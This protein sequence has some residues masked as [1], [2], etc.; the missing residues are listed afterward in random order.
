MRLRQSYTPTSNRRSVRLPVRLLVVLGGVL[1][2]L[3]MAEVGVRM[4]GFRYLNLY[5]ED[6]DVGFAHRP[7]AEGWWQREGQTYI[8]IS[9]AGLR[10]REHAQVKPPGTVRV[11]VLGDSFAEA[12]QVPMEAAFWAVAEQR[13]QGCAAMGGRRVEMLNFGVSGSSTA[14]ELITL[15]RRVWQYAPDVV[16]LLVTT[17]ND[18]RDNSRLLNR[19]YAGLPLPYFV[20]QNG[21][22]VLDD[23]LL[24]RRNES[25]SFRWHQSALGSSLNRLRDHVRLLS[26]L[27]RTRAALQTYQQKRKDTPADIGYEP[28][29]D[30]KV[31]LAP[32]DPAW[33]EAWRV[34]EGL[35]LLMR[36]EVQAHGAK[37]LLVTGSSGI[38]VYPD[39]AVRQHFMQS[40]G[41]DDLF[42]PDYRIK[43]LGE[44]EGIEILTLAPTL[45][46]YADR[47][48]T[49]LHG[50][51]GFGHWNTL[52]HRLVGDLV[53][54]RLCETTAT[55]R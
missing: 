30:T 2:G 12:L 19:E 48:K 29:L 45:Q 43:A 52:G 11:A 4:I 31:Y 18:V 36:A 33:A 44:R 1:V 6:G 7:G 53:A 24:R 28:G 3:L 9:S 50:A 41:A 21:A 34:T 17:S 42:Y 55:N 51:D 22:L 23:S 26:L 37:F 40:V 14:R 25:L 46:E 38:Q 10:D 16:L 47:N 20:Y 27:D 39:R 35:L 15:R 32:A 54:E 13:L 49:F 8:K 5:Q